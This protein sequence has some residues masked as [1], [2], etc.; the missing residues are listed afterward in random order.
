MH[1]VMKCRVLFAFRVANILGDSVPLRPGHRRRRVITS[2]DQDSIKGT[3]SLAECRDK[4]IQR[5]GTWN[6]LINS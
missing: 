1:K 2:T 6:Q 3:N 4:F 5:K